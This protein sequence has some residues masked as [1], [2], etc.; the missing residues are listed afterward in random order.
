MF[1]FFKNVDFTSLELFIA[2]IVKIPVNTSI[3]LR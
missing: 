1:E 2:Y 3:V